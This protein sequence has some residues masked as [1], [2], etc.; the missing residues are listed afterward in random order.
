MMSGIGEAVGDV[1]QGALLARAVE[2]D[3]GEA[4]EG[5]THETACLNCGTALVGPH[6]HACGQAAHVHRSLGAFFHDLLH[7]VLHFEGKIWRTL[8]LLAWRPGQLTR[9][10]IDGRRASYVGPI[11]LFLFVVFLSF[12]LFSAL[13]GSDMLDPRVDPLGQV[14]SAYTT[15]EQELTRLRTDRERADAADSAAQAR[16]EKRIAAL[17]Q[18]QSRLKMVLGNVGSEFEKDF[19]AGF[20]KSPLPQGN[21]LTQAVERVQA[22][23]QLAIYKLQTNAY[24]YSW[25]LIPLSVPFV[26]LLFPFS[27]RFGL[28]DHTVFV[29]Y[30]IAFMIAL[31]ALASLLGFFDAGGIGIVLLLYA[32]LHLYR[33]LRGTYDLGRGAAIWRMLVLSLFAWVAIGLFAA[34]VVA[35]VME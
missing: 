12:A 1:A 21:A 18:D 34:V 8:P 6:C 5:H 28:Y 29:T 33:Q 14:K 13:G 25:M 24:K 10:Y 16:I 17:E 22:N 35:L 7:G 9:E 3:H 2:A 4:S 27:R 15:N 32:P 11:A 23:P 31:V 26:W 19:R 30:S 20:E